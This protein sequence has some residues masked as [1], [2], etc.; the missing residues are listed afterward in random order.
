[1]DK[2]ENDAGGTSAVR[3]IESSLPRRWRTCWR[4]PRLPRRRLGSVLWL[5]FLILPCGSSRLAAETT[6]GQSEVRLSSPRGICADA[7][8]NILVASRGNNSV[9]L[10]KP[11]PTLRYQERATES[12]FVPYGVIEGERGGR[13]SRPHDVAVDVAGR[14]IVA[15]TG[16]D[17]V[18]IYSNILDPRRY[19]VDHLRGPL[20]RRLFSAP[21]GVATDP[22]GNLIVFD[23][24]GGKLQIF[25]PDLK[26]LAVISGSADQNPPDLSAMHP[27]SGPFLGAPI[28]GCS[29]GD[30]YLAVADRFLSTYSVWK[31]DPKSPRPE[32][33]R[34][35]GYG[36]PCEDAPNFSIR[37]IAYNS[38]RHYLA[39]LG[40]NMPLRDSAF[41]YFQPVDVDDPA[42]VVGGT[43]PCTLRIP[44]TGWLENSASLAFTPDGDLFISDA[45]SDSFQRISRESFAVLNSPVSVDAQHTRATLTYFS[46]AEVVTKLEYGAVPISIGPVLSLGRTYFDPAETFAH[47]VKLD[48]LLPS[49]RY[50]YHYLLSEDSFSSSSAV[51]VTNYSKTR[52]FA[53]QSAPR[54]MEYLDFPLDVLVFPNVPTE[55]LHSQL[56]FTRLFFWMNSRMTC[57]LKPNVISVGEERRLPQ[58][59]IL[60]QRRD[61]GAV[62]TF[63]RDLASLSS[64]RN[65][66]LI[67][68]EA[69][70]DESLRNLL[71]AT[72]GLDRQG[73]SVSLF[74][75]TG[76]DNTASFIRQYHRQLSIMHFASGRT[77]AL[78]CLVQDPSSDHSNVTWDS[79]PDLSRAL[80]RNGWLA[81]RYGV[82]RTTAD[83][84]EDDVVD[85]DPNCPL[86]EKRFGT[87]P[88]RPDTDGD[89]VEDLSEILFSRWATGFPVDGARIIANYSKPL[90]FRVDTDRDGVPDSLDTNP[91]CPL[92]DRIRRLEITVDGKI[93][94][95]EWDYASSLSI[96]DNAYDGVLRVA[97]NRT[98]LFFSL[99]GSGRGVAQGPPSIRI[100]LDGTAD[101]FLRGSDHLSLLFEPDSEGSFTVRYEESSVALLSGA[102]AAPVTPWIGFSHTIGRWTMVQDSLQAEIAIPKSP[103]IGLHLFGGEETAFDFEIRPK[104][105]SLW[106]RVF[107]PLT[108]FHATLKPPEPE[109]EMPD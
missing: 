80:G 53:T 13:L 78:S 33:C 15:D 40:T 62:E 106:L 67:A 91:L 99:T 90:P 84:D 92:G 23:T 42:R 26:D 9:I 38:Q 45:A 71:P 46:T 98:C 95:G 17:L 31:Y 43:V 48:S 88:A 59:T 20:G 69:S 105:A 3:R 12:P 47:T 7:N 39:F 49:T 14:I 83:N 94:Q 4:D 11:R 96:A 41:L 68:P 34:F 1:M 19:S 89:A 55:D 8:G 50:A 75:Y 58:P 30:G 81:N 63:L 2:T 6:R 104:G 61:E 86:D 102:S 109:M 87:S 37:S 107:E 56:E 82:F 101:G 79:I 54:R 72:C 52:L 32:T 10:L 22:Q 21:E 70:Y 103:E 57:N 35:V 66:F 73:G 76:D 85:D 65:L 18:K 44:L 74:A 24:G 5:V 28:D 16:N 93:G 100:R 51:A 77:D 64:S 25:S 108:F 97:W 27:T 29:F 36:P 60:A